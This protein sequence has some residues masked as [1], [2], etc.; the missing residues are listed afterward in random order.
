MS[1][2]TRGSDVKSYAGFCYVVNETGGG[3]QVIDL[4]NVDAGQVTLVQSVTG[5]GLTHSHNVALNPDSG[6]V[7]LC[8][9]DVSGSGGGLVAYSLADPANPVLA[10]MW[11]TRYVHDAQIVTYT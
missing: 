7:Y 9:S 11:T 1:S 10:G 8:G 6:F 4:R 2:P 3:M 5:N